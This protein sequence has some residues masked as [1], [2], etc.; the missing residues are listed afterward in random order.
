MSVTRRIN[1]LLC[2]VLTGCSA[3]PRDPEGTSE[4]IRK[5]RHFTVGFVGSAAQDPEAARLI[6]EIRRAT[7]AHV[8][9]QRGETEPLLQALATGKV[10][11]VVGRFTR[12]SPWQTAVAFAPALSRPGPKQDEIEFKAAVRNGENRWLMLVERASR[13]V[14]VEARAR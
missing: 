10:D 4:R 13:T 1:L 7:G 12:T 14:S 11:L 8:S 3:L 2:A 5:E 9:A 6:A